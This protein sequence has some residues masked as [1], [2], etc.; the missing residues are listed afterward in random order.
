MFLF[1]HFMLISAFNSAVFILVRAPPLSLYFSA[2]TVARDVDNKIY[3]PSDLPSNIRHNEHGIY[4]WPTCSALHTTTLI[5]ANNAKVHWRQSAS[6]WDQRW[7]PFQHSKISELSDSKR[8]EH[9]SG[10]VYLHSPFARIDHW[11]HFNWGL[12]SSITPIS[13]GKRGSFLVSVQCQNARSKWNEE[14]FSDRK[15]TYYLIAYA[16]CKCQRRFNKFRF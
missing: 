12:W 15:W 1:F 7:R 5:C 14:V 2:A 9:V 6:V 4:C 8:V 13:R 3:V 10:F 16:Q 11:L